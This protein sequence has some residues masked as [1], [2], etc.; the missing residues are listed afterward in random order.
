MLCH[1]M[2]QEIRGEM[3]YFT[4]VSLGKLTVSAISH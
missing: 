2:I 4:P 3:A 1:C